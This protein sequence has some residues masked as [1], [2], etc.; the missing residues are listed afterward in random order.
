M[1]S[2]NFHLP[3]TNET[4]RQFLNSSSCFFNRCKR[5]N[6][7]VKISPAPLEVMAVRQVW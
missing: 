3:K 7:E 5:S 1:S 2:F 4:V 6:N